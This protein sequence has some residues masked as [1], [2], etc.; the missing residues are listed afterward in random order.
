MQQKRTPF[1]RTIRLGLMIVSFSVCSVAVSKEGISSE[2]AI[3]TVKTAVS[4]TAVPAEPATPPVP[5]MNKTQVP[6]FYRIMV[7]QFEV[8]ALFDGVFEFHPEL[9]KNADRPVIEKALTHHYGKT[10]GIQTAVNA[11][12]IHTGEHLVL[13]DAGAGKLFSEG[14]QGRVVANLKASGYEP[15]QVDMVVMTHLHGDHTGGLSDKEGNLLFPNA[16]VYADKAENEYWLSEQQAAAAPVERQ[17]FFKMARESA[18]PYLSAEKWKTLEPGQEIVPGIRA[19]AAYGH[20]PGHTAFEVTSDGQTLLIWGDI[21]HSHAIQFNRPEVAI[22]Y[23][24]DATQAVKT[25]QALL[26]SVAKK[27]ELVAGMHLPF[28]GLGY[29]RAE[30]NGKYRWIPVEYSPLD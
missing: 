8:T 13:V 29:I 18:V 9:L 15:E 2:S 30:G 12:L 21:V 20:T 27:N 5:P 28:P 22:E 23:D 6:G 7:G 19:V 25:R 17:V 16:T 11:Y 4:E 24:S 3:T 14:G 10:S 1:C 26:N